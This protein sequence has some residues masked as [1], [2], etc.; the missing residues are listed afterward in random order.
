VL[1]PHEEAAFGLGE[2]LL[3]Q[4]RYSEAI[5]SYG[6]VVRMNPVLIEQIPSAEMQRLLRERLWGRAT[7]AR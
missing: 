5:E 7:G 4:G 3:R 2:A 6:P 1:M